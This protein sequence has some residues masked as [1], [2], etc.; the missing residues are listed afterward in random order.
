[1]EN[2][3]HLEGGPSFNGGMGYFTINPG[4]IQI[5]FWSKNKPGSDKNKYPWFEDEDVENA[6]TLSENIITAYN[7]Y[8][9][10]KEENKRLKEISKQM[11]EALV[12]VNGAQAWIDDSK[13]RLLWPKYVLPAIEKYQSIN[14]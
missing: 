5:P 8:D 11:F 6:K 1:M 12:S 13:V 10:L 3:L 14:K 7:E 4:L 2:K 9:T